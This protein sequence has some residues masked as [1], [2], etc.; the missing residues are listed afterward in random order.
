MFQYNFMKCSENFSQYSSKP[1][2]SNNSHFKDG[3][4][5][6]GLLYTFVSFVR[7]KF[8]LKINYTFKYIL[9]NFFPDE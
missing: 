8:S 5:F 1:V 4:L 9:L 2:I 3:A 6:F 7:V